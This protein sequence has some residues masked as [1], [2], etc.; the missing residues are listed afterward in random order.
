MA[1][2]VDFNPQFKSQI[3]GILGAS[4]GKDGQWLTTGEIDLHLENSRRKG[5]IMDVRWKQP[6]AS[7]RIM[8]FSLETPFPFGFPFGALVAFNQ[9][10]IE[11]KY[12]LESKSGLA[13]GVGPMGR[14]KIGGTTESVNI[15]ASCFEKIM[16]KGEEV[17]VSE[18]EHHSNIVP[19]Q[20]TAKRTGAVI[21]YIPL[22]DTGDLDLSN[23]DQYFNS[24]TKIVSITHISNVLGK[25][26]PIKDLA[27]LPIIP[28]LYS[29]W[30]AHKE[31]LIIGSM[32]KI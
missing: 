23:P 5:R 20:L 22:T 18:M 30:M 28:E 29:L 31:S 11:K 7:S 9:D 16:K 1:A 8:Y 24:K 17:I 21:K 3:G 13:T 6:D 14:W 32:F 12:L 10:F 4:R 15:I 2:V 19:W 27:K 25:I 26:N